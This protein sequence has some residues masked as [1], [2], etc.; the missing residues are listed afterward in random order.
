[1]AESYRPRRSV[2]YMPGS[3]PRALEKARTIPADALIFDLEDAVAPSAKTE[4]RRIIAEALVE[5]GYGRRE[6]IIRINGLDTEWGQDDV[7]AVAS[8][9]AD[10]ILFPKISSAVELVAAATEM[11]RAGVPERVALWAMMETPA[12]MLSA[13]EIAAAHPRL[14]C[15]VLG[16]NDL[17]KEL[18]AA[19]TPQR[20]PLLVPISL[21][22][23]AARANRLACI[24]GV[25][26]AIRDAEGFRAACVQG[27]EMG[28]DGKTLIHP[29]QVAPCNQVF[30]P[31]E[32]ELDLARRQVAAFEEAE[33]AGRAVVVVD[34]RIV[35]NLH[36]AAAKRM[37]AED[38]LI[39]KMAGN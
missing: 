29:S 11:T 25:H 10:A 19:H 39:R 8:M 9:D 34:G 2:L 21:C 17:A 1:M 35:E 30:A 26:N 16:T 15:F 38:S 4:A 5:G 20:L 36:V 31:T 24:D 18:G 32:A 6:R 7:S 3:N 23:L 12:S 22:L 14:A 13:A 28:F 33:S 37:L 27:R